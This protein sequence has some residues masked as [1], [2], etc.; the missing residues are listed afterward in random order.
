MLK[1][2]SSLL[3]SNDEKMARKQF[4]MLYSCLFALVA[5]VVFFHYIQYGVTFVR[6]GDGYYQH[7]T[8][9]E[10][11]GK[12][13]RQI[14]RT[15][16]SE[17]KLVI[18]NWDFSIGLGS[19]VITTFNYYVLGD[20]L[21]LLSVLVPVKY[22]PYLYTFLCV[23]RYYL[24]GLC[25]SLYCFERKYS[26][27]IGVLVSAFTYTFCSYALYAG[28]MHPYFINP[29]IYLPLILI[30][31]E[32]IFK[33]RNPI[34]LALIVCVAEVSNFYFFYVVVIATVVYVLLRLFEI[35]K[36]DIK[37]MIAPLFKIAA[38]SVTGV[39]LGAVIF[40]PVVLKL[41]ADS[42]VGVKY[43]YAL[44]YAL[45]Y[46]LRLPG[47]MISHNYKGGWTLLGYSV[48]ILFAVAVL[49]TVRKKRTFLKIFFLIGLGGFASPMFAGFAN[50]F[51]YPCNRWG[52][53]FSFI[54]SFVVASTWDELFCLENK[55]RL[56]IV[57]VAPVVY[58]GL[59]F[60]TDQ[61]VKDRMIVSTL[62]VIVICAGLLISGF[63]MKNNKTSQMIIKSTVAFLCI[64]CIGTNAHFVF[65]DVDEKYYSKEFI[66]NYNS[67]K[68]VDSIS[69]KKAA[70]AD[71][72]TEFYR[73]SGDSLSVNNTVR[74]GMSNTQYYWSLSDES[75]SDFHESISI[76]ESYYQFY[77]GFDDITSLNT[78]A[79]VKYFYN[80]PKDNNTNV[81]YGFV[82]TETE[83][84]YRNENAL[85]LGYTYDGYITRAEYDALETSLDKQQAIMQSVVLEEGDTYSVKA[86]PEYNT[87]E[88]EKKL[89]INTEDVVYADKA[90]TVTK[91]NAKVYFKIEP[92]ENSELY[93]SLKD[94]SYE[95]TSL[96]SLYGDDTS[97][98]PNNRYTPEDFE[99]LDEVKQDKIKKNHL[100]W[101]EQTI[102][103][104]AA[105]T[106]D[107]DK[108]IISGKEI[109]YFTPNFT[110]Y[111]NKTSF[112][113]NLGYSEDGCEYVVLRFPYIGTYTFSDIA[114]YAQ[115]MSLYE[116][117]VNERA[118]TV[119]QN[120]NITTD[121][122]TGN[123]SADSD[124]L[125]CLSIPYSKGWTAYVDGEETKLMKANVM[126]MAL[127]ISEGDHEIELRYTVP[128]I[129]IGA[130][131]TIF[132]LLLLFAYYMWYYIG[133]K[134]NR[135]VFKEID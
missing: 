51:S 45:K 127:E 121:R 117:S 87:K 21:T 42:R 70:E 83:N 48:I 102:I 120:V 62:S 27:V 63:V 7:Y 108:N 43:D 65:F 41:F 80:Y 12:W 57:A 119:L 115:D 103:P 16:L 75:I 122:V 17:G 5:F 91:E 55:K 2:K 38:S 30:S 104:F 50:G 129:K 54:I 99:K 60:L 46:Y 96:Y 36:T 71:G 20:P 69:V 90:F 124:K 78:L 3:M 110:F 32:K 10:Y 9:L 68:A 25:F 77:N 107:S 40:L 123:I 61:T 118:E 84:V 33:N 66:N 112:D 113:A 82:E 24:I 85:P 131:F 93:I 35:F 28:T 81:P 44:F 86:E 97:V 56:I 67:S 19:D 11:F 133:R 8:A 98:D 100:Y 58:T 125:L 15:L 59:C 132:G 95:G 130:I 116:K 4:L 109:Q 128:T 105:G 135:I 88:L 37:A 13:L 126:Y 72:Q 34:Y 114:I 53:V 111:C 47:A 29:M 92:Q 73:F 89:I 6:N 18:P 52:F 22:T 79:G 64:A 76:N 14:V 101:S 39:L 49:F 31:V 94:I 74:N 134:K 23:F 1:S 26:N 106:I